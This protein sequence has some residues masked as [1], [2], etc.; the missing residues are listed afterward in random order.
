VQ[1][2]ATTFPAQAERA[3]RINSVGSGLAEAD[4]AAVLPLPQLEAVVIP[5]VEHAWHVHLVASAVAAL[6]PAGRYAPPHARTHHT[7]THTHVR[8]YMHAHTYAHSGVVGSRR[9]A[10][11][12]LIACI[13]SALGVMNLREIAG[14]DARLDGLVFASE[15]YC[16]DVGATRTRDRRELLYARS[17]VVT[18]A[19]AHRLQVRRPSPYADAEAGLRVVG[20]LTALASALGN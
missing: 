20:A 15:D 7:H 17:A 6:A 10:P 9:D 3:V 19:A 12:R 1:A 11:V 14:A 8:T 16:A 18:A 4:L 13:E 5:K 2:A